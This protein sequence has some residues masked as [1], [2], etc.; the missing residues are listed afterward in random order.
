MEEDAAQVVESV[1]GAAL[2]GL[3][4]AVGEVEAGELREAVEGSP[5]HDGDGVGA[6]R[7]RH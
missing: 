1:E 6:Q 7:Q 3:D 4:A 5:R 2:D